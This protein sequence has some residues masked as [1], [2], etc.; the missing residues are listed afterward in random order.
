MT[1]QKY[2]LGIDVS[3]TGAKALI[4]DQSGGVVS[5]ATTPLTLF[6]PHLLWSEQDP[7][8]LERLPLSRRGAHRGREQT[9]D[10]ARPLGKERTPCRTVR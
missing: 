8:A 4:I 3:T 6:T 9:G 2:L 7:S 10:V 5:S 1:S